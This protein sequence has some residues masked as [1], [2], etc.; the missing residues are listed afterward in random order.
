MGC[1]TGGQKFRFDYNIP[2]DYINGA[3]IRRER[4]VSVWIT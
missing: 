2:K 1:K 3:I 4:E